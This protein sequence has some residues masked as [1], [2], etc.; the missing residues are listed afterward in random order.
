[1]TRTV[2]AFLPVSGQP[3]ALVATFE[4]DPKRW[5]PDGRRDGPDDY[6]FMVTAGSLTRP[7]SARI[8]APW[9]SG[10]T[11]WRSICWDPVAEDGNRG[12]LD[13]MLPSLDAELGLHI[14]APDRVTLLLD[15][16]YRPPGGAVGL[17]A[18]TIALGR[19][20][21]STVE[22]VLEE[23][24][25]RLAAATLLQQEAPTRTPSASG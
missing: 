8:G 2:R 24:V 11:R 5:L 20:A 1:M 17:A 21:R 12:T 4:G 15:G 22:H 23:I 16:R 19:V 14:G 9:R 13:R 25:A 10:A 18:D 3:D 7:V 6:V